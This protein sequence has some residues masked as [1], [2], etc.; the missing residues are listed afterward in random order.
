M[1]RSPSVSDVTREALQSGNLLSHDGVG[2]SVARDD[3]ILQPVNVRLQSRRRCA[4][5]VRE[6]RKQLPP[7]LLGCRE[8]DGHIVE[9]IRECAKLAT[10]TIGE[11]QLRCSLQRRLLPAAWASCSIGSLI[12]RVSS[13]DKNPPQ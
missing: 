2:R 9:G 10:E 7:R 5:F 4:Q 3:A 11:E 12:L 13:H 6:V 1:H 8:L